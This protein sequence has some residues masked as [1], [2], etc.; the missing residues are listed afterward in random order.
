MT[1]KKITWRCLYCK[2]ENLEKAKACKWCGETK[3]VYT[4]MAVMEEVNFPIN[5]IDV[6]H[7]QGVMN[8][9]QAASLIN[10]AYI[11]AGIGNMTRDTQLDNNRN[12]FTR[13]NVPWGL[14]WYLK[15]AYDW[16]KH[17]ASIVTV[18][19][20][21]GWSLPFWADTEENGGLNKVLLEGWLYKLVR[22]VEQGIGKELII[23]TGPYFW[24]TNMPLTNWAKNRRLA[25]ANYTSASQPIIPNEWANASQPR[26]WTFWQW[27]ADGNNKG[28]L[29]G[30]QSDDIDLDRFN[31]DAAKFKQIFGVDPHPVGTPPVTFPKPLKILIPTLN[32]RNGSNSSN[33]K[34]GEIYQNAVMIAEE[35]KV[36]SASEVWVRVGE[37]LWVARI[38]AGKIYAIYM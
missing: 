13:E 20:E 38:F 33:T 14:Y 2:G 27:S 31:G 5:G 21:G 16:K 4:S 30:A 34:L 12:G 9:A 22:D 35:E 7:F 18:L 24:N 25:I 36:I 1:T 11:R 19:N 28:R 26:T 6:S 32:I 3:S 23:Y 17:V 15:P 8:H 10:F 29:Y 37:N